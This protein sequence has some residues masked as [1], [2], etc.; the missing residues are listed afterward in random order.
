MECKL[1]NTTP[2]LK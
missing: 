1:S 2:F